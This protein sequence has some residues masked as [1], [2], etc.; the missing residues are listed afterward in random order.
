M[1][2][3]KIQGPSK[4]IIINVPLVEGMHLR[5]LLLSIA[6]GTQCVPSFK[7]HCGAL[8]F[9]LHIALNVQTLIN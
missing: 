8:Y 2:L 5:C 4:H 9:P 1:L 7:W 6:Y 3:H